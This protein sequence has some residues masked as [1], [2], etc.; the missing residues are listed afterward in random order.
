M[1][2]A[3]SVPATEEPP[4]FETIT[5]PRRLS[6]D[7]VRAPALTRSGKPDIDL[8]ADRAIATPTTQPQPTTAASTPASTQR[9][10]RP[11]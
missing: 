8:D 11:P 10:V 9:A 5:D 6:F 4:T 2:N 1:A 7:R 3:T